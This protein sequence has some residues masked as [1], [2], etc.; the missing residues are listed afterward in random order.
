MLRV[1]SYIQIPTDQLKL[2]GGLVMHEGAKATSRNSGRFTPTPGL[3]ELA[4][5]ESD[6]QGQIHSPDIASDRI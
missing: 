4:A 2:L 5:Q 6:H 3:C 1:S